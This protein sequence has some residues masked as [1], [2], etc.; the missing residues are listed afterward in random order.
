GEVTR[1]RGKHIDS[2]Q[3]I[4]CVEQS[5]GRKD[6]LVMLSPETLGLLREWWKGRPTRWDAMVSSQDRLLF[7]G[8]KPGQP[9]TP[10]Q[11]NRLLHGTAEAGGTRNA[12]KLK[13]LRPS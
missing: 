9:L 6:R 8:R 13:P 2:A 7:P 5:K 10:R 12:V 11:L 1:L 3:N 4:I